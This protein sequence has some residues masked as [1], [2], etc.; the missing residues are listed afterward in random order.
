[1]K[2]LIKIMVPVLAIMTGVTS[3]DKL[4]TTTTPT[5]TTPTTTTPT[6]PTPVTPSPSG[7]YWGVLAAV[8]M[9]FAYSN[10]QIPIPIS[11]KS[12]V[13]SASFFDGAGSS[14]LTGAGTVSIN[15][16][17]LKN[18]NN[19]YSLTASD[20]MTPSTLNLTGS[21]IDWSVGGSGNVAAF[22]YSHTGSM[23]NYSGT[24]SLPTAIDRTKD[25][26]ITLGNKV[27][28][29]D[30]V[31]VLIITPNSSTPLMKA[32]SA[33][34]SAPAK[35]TFTASELGSLSSVADNGAYVEVVAFR[36]AVPNINSRQYVFV[37]EFAAVTTATIN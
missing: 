4:P 29:A 26:D 31:Y 18:N 3:C 6:S 37:K 20:G 10:P 21:S 13:A 22:T 2:K 8:Q 33:K 35:A 23:P 15:S 12:D 17:D 27:T 25:L 14:N 9:E 5:T 28:N 11:I 34:P 24:S 7:S 19:S 36:Y 16:N 30:S 32:Y 1:M